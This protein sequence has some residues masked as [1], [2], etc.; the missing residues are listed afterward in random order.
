MIYL[1]KHLK[2]ISIY[3]VIYFIHRFF[4]LY[5]LVEGDFANTP[6]SEEMIIHNSN[7]LD[8]RVNGFIAQISWTI[9]PGIEAIL[10]SILPGRPQSL[11]EF[12]VYA[13]NEFTTWFSMKKKLLKGTIVMVDN[14]EQA[15]SLV[16]SA[17]M[18]S[19]N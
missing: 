17:I 19:R 5:D 3:F 13:N 1:K 10:C 14:F 15:E 4:Y 2:I 6:Y 7:L 18:I 11:L 8:N 12:A 16:V 9:T